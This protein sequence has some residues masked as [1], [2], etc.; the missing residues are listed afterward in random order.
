M[1]N[2]FYM[3]RSL[4]L[5]SY[6]LIFLYATSFA[7]VNPQNGAAQISI[8]LY[9]FS[10]PGNR[11]GL[12]ANLIYFDGNGLK[13]S[14]IAGAVGTG[15]NLD[16]GGC[17]SR[18]QHGEPD[19]Q[20]NSSF[21]YTNFYTNAGLYATSYF[22]N[23]YLYNTSGSS[24]PYLPTDVIT[25]EGAYS[26]YTQNF[27]LGNY[28]QPPQIIADRDQDIFQFSFNGRSG[29]F[30]IG[31]N[32]KPVTLAD[33][34]LL[35]SFQQT[36]MS[37]SHIRTMISQFT[38]TDESGIQYIF[39]DLELGNVCQYTD[40]R[41]L[42]TDNANVCQTTSN[43]LS[44]IGYLRNNG[45]AI[46][47][48]L[49]V[50]NNQFVVNK[51]YLSQIVNPFTGKQIT[52]N[53]T[54]YSEDMRTDKILSSTSSSSGSGN[55]IV[56][57]QRY[58]IQ[59]K[60]LSSV[61]LSPNQSVNLIYSSS[62]RID[63]PNENALSQLQVNYKNN[64]VY[65][66]MFVYGY[67]VGIDKAIKQPGDTYTATEQQWSRLCL[68][69][70]QKTGI[71][72]VSEAPYKFAYNLGGSYSADVV[73][74]MCSIYQDHYGYYNVGAVT[75]D[76]TEGSA[77]SFY[78]ISG[79]VS[80]L[81]NG[82][83]YNKNV[84][85][86][87][88]KNGIIQSITYP[89]GGTLTY[90]YQ[91][92]NTP[93]GLIGG[94]SVS[95]TTQYDG[96]STNNNIIKQYNYVTSDESTSSG[97]GGETY[98][99]TLTGTSTADGCNSAET[100]VA[101]ESEIATN[102]A[103]RGMTALGGSAAITS[104]TSSALIAQIGEFA[105]FVSIAFY[106]GTLLEGNEL[107][108]V[109]TNYTEKLN[110]SLVSGNPLPWGYART[111]VVTLNGTGT[112]GKTVYEYSCP[113]C[114]GDQPIEYPAL[115][116]P[117][118]NRPRY[119]PWVY[120]VPK[121]VTV[122]DN[123]NNPIKET[124]NH[125]T[126]IVDSLTT[127]DF[128]SKSWTPTGSVYG[129]LIQT[130]DQTST[131]I[132]QETYYPYTGHTQLNSTD[133]IL[134]NSAQQSSTITTYY[135]YDGNYQLIDKYSTNS[136]GEKIQI[137]YYYPYNYPTS[138]AP[139][140]E[141]NTA[142]YNI[143][144]PVISSETYLT[145]LSNNKYLLSANA[146]AFAQVV[147]GD[148]KPLTLYTFQTQYPTPVANIGSF[149]PSNI[150]RNSSYIPAVFYGYDSYGNLVQT[151]TGGNK[152]VSSIYDYD[153]KLPIATAVNASYNDIGHTSFEAE[154]A[155]TGAW[156]NMAA[157][158]STDARTGNSC[159]NLSDPSNATGNYFGFSGLNNS[160]SYIVSFWSKNGSAC[161]IGSRSGSQ[162]VS[163]CQGSSGWTQG[164]TVNG[165]TYYE[166]QVNN[167]DKIGASG[168]GLIDEFRVF[169][170]GA[171]MTTTTYAPLIGKTSECDASNKVTY[172]Q[173]DELGR[174]R[175][176]MDDQKNIVRMY[177]YNYKQ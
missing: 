64:P 79:L 29:E 177:D 170:V 154:G 128:I 96:I 11:I 138:N 51:W 7:Q 55:P 144:G 139:I 89:M 50:P 141:M 169:P 143:F 132:N 41:V 145:D 57:W 3:K 165:W 95:T 120:G 21:P 49:G 160:L 137:N 112:T 9:S 161:L 114:S 15:W 107:P 53:Y 24:S 65:S 47:V 75:N 147:N 2:V 8:P 56:F 124:I 1:T 155:K 77:T 13:A 26:P 90:T 87:V 70:L 92:N 153:G 62:P 129:C 82:F 73:P 59:G 27:G 97:W 74:P 157:I 134:F 58:M 131:F 68:T 115:A 166:V 54:T 110:R 126:Y 175:F 72:N 45:T 46:S 136:K 23:G 33:S 32:G 84:E 142:G 104:M 109:T 69:S 67:M 81:N 127:S 146:T 174:L 135:D 167:I 25:N 99:Y 116:V 22:P 85:G 78:T 94:V 121:T 17:I 113:T 19:D 12:N 152:I 63:L 60:R 42:Y 164:T 20:N 34:K 4:Y 31:K 111:E 156:T 98:T 101:I 37:A 149:N 150:V 102:L 119:A 105:D 61:I 93:A 140:P 148:Y 83:G 88:A 176:I 162:V 14:E 43:A 16:F 44:S 66:W 38:I 158:V 18:I 36:D 133:E 130:A 151:V 171:Q 125:Y 5:L 48:V 10:D 6:C 100:P 35:I 40:L 71:N 172:Y 168:T 91:N 123:L 28:K 108:T 30:V 80:L 86:T 39:K 159:F 52:F 163:T 117:Y 122:Y 103:E 173:Y 118:S 76:V 106:I